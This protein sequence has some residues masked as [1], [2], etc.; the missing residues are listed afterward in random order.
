MSHYKH[1]TPE[2]R[3]K[4]LILRSKNYT[5]TDIATSIGRNKAT[6]SRELMRNSVDGNYSA[7]YAQ[8]AYEKRRNSCRP[9]KKLSD[10][11]IFNTVREKFLDH[12]WSPEQI[13][14][15]IK[16]ECASFS[17]SCTTIYRGIY[18]GLF[19]TAEE[20]RSDGNRGAR[21]KLRHRGKTRHTKDH[22]ET[23]GK[24]VISNDISERPSEANDRSRIGDWE[25]DTVAGKNSGPCLVTLA[26][27]M[28]RFLLSRKAE[29]KNSIYVRDTMIQCL[30]GQPLHSITPDRGKEF[31]RHAEVT[32][33]LNNV[34]FYFPQPHQPWRRGTNENTNGLLREYFPKG[35]DLSKYSDEQIQSK[36]DELNKRP[37]K[38]LGYRTPYEVYYST[39]LLLI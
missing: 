14:E 10:P 21:R 31:A 19:D 24:I 22:K 2:E 38:C 5:I 15:R 32:A 33:A 30:Q 7:V 9:K 28:S 4:I 6:I 3:E 29:K 11:L 13:A 34:L 16:H 36:V 17:I 23:R 18:A 20:R 26:D 25:G 39:T 12:Q 1:I 27:R 8:S 35:T 37:R